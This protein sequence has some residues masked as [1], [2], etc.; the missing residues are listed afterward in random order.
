MSAFSC[1]ALIA[2]H[3]LALMPRRGGWVR[4][5]LYV[6]QQ[7]ARFVIEPLAITTQAHALGQVGMAKGNLAQVE[8]IVASCD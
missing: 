1:G 3:L 5:R 8:L 6:R 7:G 2:G 4:W